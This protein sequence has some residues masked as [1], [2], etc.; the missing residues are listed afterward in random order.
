M[1]SMAT[2]FR[3]VLAIFLQDIANMVQPYGEYAVLLQ[4]IVSAVALQSY[5]CK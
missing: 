4:C 3:A 2:L 1:V 5:F